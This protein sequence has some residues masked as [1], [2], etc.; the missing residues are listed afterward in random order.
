M[1]SGGEKPQRNSAEPDDGLTEAEP[2]NVR[3]HIGPLRSDAHE[4]LAKRSRMRPDP[5]ARVRA[6]GE[7]QNRYGMTAGLIL[8]LSVHG[9]GAAHGFTSLIDLGAFAALVQS[10]VRD[11]V[12]ATYAVE[13]APAKPPPPPPPAEPP[14]P[15]PEPQ[16]KAVS[17]VAQAEAP[18]P[19]PAQAGKVLTAAPDPDAPLDLT[20][21]GFV[22][23]DG[24]HYVGG[25]TSAK[26]TST[27]AVRQIQ[28]KNGGKIGSR[29]N[30]NL[31]SIATKQDLSR[32]STPADTSWNDCGFPP[33][34]DTDQI[35]FMRVRIMVTVGVERAGAKSLGAQRPRTR[36]WAPSATMRISKVIQRGVEYRR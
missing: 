24:D 30:G 25:V 21:D 6:L 12:R 13:V 33:E 34:A 23:G 15:E 2:A 28:A 16:P 32:A 1:S 14:P 9:A 11:D 8:A 7:R 10:A 3:A 20:G 36:L 18:P 29:G 19:S 27:S 31:D 22:T 5:L 26:G 35:N 4:V 17:R